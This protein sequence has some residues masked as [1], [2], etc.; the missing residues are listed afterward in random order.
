MSTWV[1]APSR[2]FA[3][4]NAPV[5]RR[6]LLRA[7]GLAAPAALGAPGLLAR[8]RLRVTL[9]L[10]SRSALTQLPLLLAEQLGMFRLEQLDVEFVETGTDGRTVQAVQAGQG[11]PTAQ[12]GA[13]ALAA[14]VGSAGF[15]DMLGRIAAGQPLQAFVAQT[16]SPLL[17]LGVATRSPTPIQRVA[18][19]R[20]RSIA[21][22]LGGVT[23]SAAVMLSLQQAGVGSHEINWTG[24]PSL[25]AASSALRGGQI[26]AI[27][28]PDPKVS[29]LEQSGDLRVLADIRSQSGSHAVFGGLL[30]ASV[31][32][33]SADWLQRNPATAQA[34]SHATVRALKW[35]QTAGMGDII[36]AVPEGSLGAD[37]ALYLAAFGKVRGSFSQDGL[38]PPDVSVT[39]PRA[40]RAVDVNARLERFDAMRSYTNQFARAAK[41]RF[42]A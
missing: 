24:L 3:G 10:D 40:M 37:R 34:L 36:K 42:G 20:G 14:E 18:D 12:N 16:T 9:A 17:A 28:A 21:V 13:P 33:A 35:L 39:G 27:C 22:P 7:L 29:Q 31:L 41:Q 2:R 4:S 6:T 25:T 1:D 11:T 23:A 19:L 15:A 38:M 8:E 30:P 32:F 26:H 5:R